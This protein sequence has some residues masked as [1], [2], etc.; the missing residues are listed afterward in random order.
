MNPP[1]PVTSKSHR[2]GQQPIV[3]IRIDPSSSRCKAVPATPRLD[4]QVADLMISIREICAHSLKDVTVQG[5]P[6]RIL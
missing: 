2:W 5:K 4:V 1:P 6:W 3:E